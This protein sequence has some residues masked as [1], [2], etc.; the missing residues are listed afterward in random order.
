V[1]LVSDDRE[2]AVETVLAQGVCC[3]DAGD[4]AADDHDAPR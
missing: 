4:P 2:I 3:R 1:P